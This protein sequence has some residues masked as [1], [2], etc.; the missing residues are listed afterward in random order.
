MKIE[1]MTKSGKYID[2]D[3][4][5]RNDRVKINNIVEFEGFIKQ[6]NKTARAILE[7]NKSL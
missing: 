5:F 4:F 7:L 2:I 6:V 3:I 1:I